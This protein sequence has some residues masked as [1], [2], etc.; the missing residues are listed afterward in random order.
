MWVST[1][2]RRPWVPMEPRT[3]IW[4][5]AWPLETR[6]PGGPTGVRRGCRPQRGFCSRPMKPGSLRR[7]RSGWVL[8]VAQLS[9]RS[10]AA[11]SR[12]RSRGRLE[13]RR[14]RQGCARM[15]P[16]PVPRPTRR[17]PVA[18]TARLPMARTARLPTARMD[19]GRGPPTDLARVRVL[20]REL[21]RRDSG[22]KAA[23]R[24][25]AP[26]AVP[27]R[28]A[29]RGTVQGRRG[30]G[31]WKSRPLRRGRRDR[32]R[33]RGSSPQP[34]RRRPRARATPRPGSC[35]VARRRL[36]PRCSAPAGPHRRSWA[37]ASW[38]RAAA[39]RTYR[40]RPGPP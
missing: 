2:A 8:P 1:G 21:S 13:A 33:P 7:K 14:S 12:L 27:A 38:R 18:R 34:A 10:T 16:R 23:A 30:G 15:R 29:W 36:G 39:F 6:K 5:P 4:V 25:G 35:R 26:G 22:Q 9:W 19:S 40:S 31:R 11:A 24:R 17:P 3:A 37:L 20:G 28:A 32:A